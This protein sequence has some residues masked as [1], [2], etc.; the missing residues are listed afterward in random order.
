MT[1]G[2]THMLV[3][4]TTRPPDNEVKE[5]AKD[6]SDGR[7]EELSY[8]D[9]P[10]SSGSA[11]SRRRNRVIRT[12]SIYHSPPPPTHHNHNVVKLC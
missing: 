2:G 9:L 10:V 11:R 1:C 3:L 12:Q 8:S 7:L 6:A 5:M 4:A